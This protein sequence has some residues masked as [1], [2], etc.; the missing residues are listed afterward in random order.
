[1]LKFEFLHRHPV[2]RRL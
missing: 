1:M 2:G